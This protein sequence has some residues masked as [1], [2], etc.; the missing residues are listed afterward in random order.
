MYKN[1]KEN[2][3]KT[4]KNPGGDVKNVINCLNSMARMIAIVMQTHTDNDLILK[5][6]LSIRIFLRTAEDL[7]KALRQQDDKPIWISRS[8]YLS[9]LNLPRQMEM[10]GPLRLY[11]EGGWK[12]EGIIKEIK[13]IIRDGLKKNWAENTLKRVYN[14]RAFDYMLKSNKLNFINKNTVR[15][16]KKYHSLNE[17]NDAFL[18]HDAISVIV[19][20][21][22]NHIVSIGN[23][24]SIILQRKGIHEKIH[25][26]VYYYWNLDMQTNLLQFPE[27]DKI[28]CYAILLPWY[29]VGLNN[30]INHSIT[31]SYTS[32]SSTWMEL[33][34]VSYILP[35]GLS[36]NDFNK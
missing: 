27:K 33:N 5:C 1:R 18:N 12:G 19:L 24:R 35:E 26:S 16:Y 21:N 4:I 9:L 25:N 22:D 17:L 30:D 15:E 13:E 6:D 20:K 28:L 8:N 34:G 23:D 36:S 32:I 2:A 31:P 14:G 29:Q 7:N 10:F 11:W 3:L